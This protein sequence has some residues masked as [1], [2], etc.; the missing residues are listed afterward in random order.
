M[1]AGHRD[2]LYGVARRLAGPADAE[3][4]TAEAFLRAYRAMTGYDA[5]RLEA[6]DH[7]PWL[8]TILLN[9]WRNRLR[10]ASRRPATAPLSTHDDRGRADGEV[11]DRHDLGLALAQ[12]PMTQRAAVVLRHVADLPTAEV[13]AVLRCPEA[14]ARSHVARGLRRL[15]S[16][17]ELPDA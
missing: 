7:R 3:D 1:Y 6:L 2:T 17:L 14:T 11:V 5:D 9:E 10:A 12:L 4:L 13:A 15:R 8:L 16:I